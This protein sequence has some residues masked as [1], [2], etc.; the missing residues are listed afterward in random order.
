MNISKFGLGLSVTAAL[1][2]VA[3]GDDSSSSSPS[4]VDEPGNLSSSSETSVTPS[5]SSVSENKT[6]SSSTETLSSSSVEAEP[7]TFAA[8]DKVW[9]ISYTGTDSYS[10]N[11]K[12]KTTF[13]IEG[14]DLL[15]RDSIRYTGNQA[16]MFCR[17]SDGPVEITSVDGK[18]SAT[19]SCDGSAV[20]F[21]GTIRESG[22]FAA[23]S[24][25]TVHAAVQKACGVAVNGG[26]YDAVPLAT[27]TS[28]DFTLEDTVW[29][30]SYID[31]GYHGDSVIISQIF[32][33]GEDNL[34]V[35][36]EEKPMQHAE[37][38]AKN[39]A[40]Y[41]SLNYCG[42]NGMIE[43]SSSGILSEKEELLNSE[44]RTCMEKLP[45]PD[46][47][48]PD[49]EEGV[50][51]SGMVSCDI[52]GVMGECVEYPAGSDEAIAMKEQCESILEGTLG[53]GCAN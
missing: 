6:S 2:L 39:F 45:A 27:T 4:F 3:C 8:T 23:N 44:K 19:K 28:C 38:V 1:C 22:Y 37:C 51:V 10:N 47:D 53:T 15:I 14:K 7:C 5:S 11:A 42:A 48:D 29:S 41:S 40:T 26:T 31:E 36:A 30:Y 20:I 24:I 12:I 43:L 35:N 33:F 52:P 25:D 16:T 32:L 18:F 34:R 9:E 49:A 17:L 46:K 50:V 13:E 21:V